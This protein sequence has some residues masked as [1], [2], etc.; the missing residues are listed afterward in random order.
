M[1]VLPQDIAQ[2]AQQLVD[3][4]DAVVVH[5]TDP[6]DTARFHE[7]ER[8]GHLDRVVVPAPHE[9]IPFRQRVRD[10]VRRNTL[11]RE[12]DRRH[13]PVERVGDPLHCDAVERLQSANLLA[14]LYELEGRF[15]ESEALYREVLQGASVPGFADYV[16]N[17]IQNRI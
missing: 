11:V 6:H 16:S 10:R 14:Q 1:R 9:D 5:G 3:L 7:S 13:A 8:G 17:A 2:R 4:R 12:R 15:E